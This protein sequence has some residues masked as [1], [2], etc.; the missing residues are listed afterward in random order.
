MVLR[1]HYQIK[2]SKI[3]A[4]LSSFILLHT[5]EGPTPYPLVFG[6]ILEIDATNVMTTTEGLERDLVDWSKS[7]QLYPWHEV[8]EEIMRGLGDALGIGGGHDKYH[9]EMMVRWDDDGA[10]QENTKQHVDITVKTGKLS[11][12]SSTQVQFLKAACRGRPY[13]S[14]G[15]LKV[16]EAHPM[17]LLCAHEGPV[18]VNY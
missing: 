9:L 2:P 3:H 18:C 17:L 11:G 5:G 10:L 6:Y 8:V 13:I 1:D 16:P 15:V 7:L 4:S 14:W 12:F